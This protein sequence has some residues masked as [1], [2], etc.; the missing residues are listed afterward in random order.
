MD[1]KTE[2]FK[3]VIKSVIYEDTDNSTFEACRNYYKLFPQDEQDKFPTFFELSQTGINLERPKDFGFGV[4]HFINYMEKRGWKFQ[5][6]NVDN[7]ELSITYRVVHP[8][9]VEYGHRQ[10]DIDL[11]KYQSSIN[12]PFLLEKMYYEFGFINDNCDPV[13]L[14]KGCKCADECWSGIEDRKPKDNEEQWSYLSFPWIGE[15]YYKNKIMVLGINTNEGGGFDFNKEIVTGARAELR[16]GRKRVN[17]GYV[18][19]N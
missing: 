8:V 19:P 1:N 15:K 12:L 6:K 17:F 11:S 2:N 7:F 14:Y 3:N 5:K 18:Y 4:D 9:D 16:E 10:W 13:S